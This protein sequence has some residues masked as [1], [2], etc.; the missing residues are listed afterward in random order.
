VSST[1]GDLVRGVV[2]LSCSNGLSPDR[3]LSMRALDR[4]GGSVIVQG[5]MTATGGLSIASLMQHQRC[6]H[7]QHRRADQPGLGGLRVSS[8][9]TV[10]A[11]A[12]QIT[13]LA[14]AS[15]F[16]TTGS[17]TADSVAITGIVGAGAI[18]TPGAATANTLAVT[19]AVAAG[20]LSTSGFVSAGGAMSVAGA[21]TA[22]SVSSAGPLTGTA[23]QR[24]WQACSMPVAPTCRAR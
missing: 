22:G 14:R 18:S 24:W 4:L 15:A 6:R 2:L 9:G 7:R 8:T 21:L 11:A 19:G 5:S 3:R 16:S 10:T 12:A 23:P 17:L 13:G 1:G 20:A